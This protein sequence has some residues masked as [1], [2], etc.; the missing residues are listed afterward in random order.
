[1]CVRRGSVQRSDRFE[2]VLTSCVFAQVDYSDMG[3]SAFVKVT[4][5]SKA[6]PPVR[7]SATVFTR[8]V[9]AAVGTS[10]A[11]WTEQ[12]VLSPHDH[13]QVCQFAC[14]TCDNVR[15]RVSRCD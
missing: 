10:A 3:T 8:S 1:M 7:G 4:R 14:V 12:A 11:F 5:V 9:T 13:Q 6:T 15:T 2:F